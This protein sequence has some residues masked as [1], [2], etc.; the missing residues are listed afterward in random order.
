MSTSG[1]LS[2]ARLIFVFLLVVNAVLFSQTRHGRLSNSLEVGRSR[3]LWKRSGSGVLP[4]GMDNDGENPEDKVSYVSLK[5]PSLRHCA[6]SL[7]LVRG[8]NIASATREP[9]QLSGNAK[10]QD[11]LFHSI[12]LIFD[13]SSIN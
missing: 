1:S 11:L 12:P 8:T 5:S 2:R 9:T 13:I 10:T 7:G 4:L 6:L 3:S